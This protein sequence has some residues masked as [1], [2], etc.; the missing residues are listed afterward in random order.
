LVP[1]VFVLVLTTL[2]AGA[3]KGA[4]ML[5]LL[6][7]LIIVLVLSTGIIN[8]LLRFYA[9]AMVYIVLVHALVPLV[10]LVYLC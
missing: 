9:C 6:E 2:C 4:C 8:K 5:V 7:V 10:V 1:L 3:I